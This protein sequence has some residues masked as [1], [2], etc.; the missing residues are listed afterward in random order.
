[1]NGLW[2]GRLLPLAA[3]P[4]MGRAAF[5]GVFVLLL[6]WLLVMPRRLVAPEGEPAWWRSPR[7]WAVAV[8]AIQILVYLRWG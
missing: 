8:T 6:I 5:V 1:M 7:V 3:G 4:L 2:L